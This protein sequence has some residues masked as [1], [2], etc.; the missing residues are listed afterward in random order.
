MVSAGYSLSV[1][2]NGSVKAGAFVSFE[3]ADAEGR[4]FYN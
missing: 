2:R 1:W 4:R 3:F